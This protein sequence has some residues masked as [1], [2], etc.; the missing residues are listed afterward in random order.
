MTNAIAAMN[1]TQIDIAYK[2][3]EF[4]KEFEQVDIET[5]HIIHGGMYSRTILLRRGVTLS[6]AL[7][8]IPTLLIL[9]GDIHI[10]IGDDV[11]HFIGYNIIPASKNRK[12]IMTANTDTYVTMVFAT[13]SGTIDDV[14]KEFT[15]E[16]ESL[17]SSKDGSLNTI[18]ITKE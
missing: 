14:E 16:W 4:I 8:K 3:E 15:D 2:A 1:D 13:D 17:I 11:K 6:G 18:T 5:N 7:I 9:S 10:Y 12:Q